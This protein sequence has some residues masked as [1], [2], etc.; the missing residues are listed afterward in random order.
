MDCNSFDVLKVSRAE[1]NFIYKCD[2][3]TGDSGWAFV[4]Y[5]EDC[6]WHLQGVKSARGMIEQKESTDEG[7]NEIEHSAKSLIGSNAQG[8]LGL[9]ATA[10]LLENFIDL[11]EIS[12]LEVILEIQ[13]HENNT[14]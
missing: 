1:H 2:I 11:N 8:G 12:V 10:F 7:L 3:W 6:S 13:N 4:T 9:L 5:R 14:K